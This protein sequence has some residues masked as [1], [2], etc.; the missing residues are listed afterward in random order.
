M[1]VVIVVVV[2]VGGVLIVRSRQV[3]RSVDALCTQMVAAQDLDQAFTTLDPATLDPQVKALEKARQ[4][5]PADIEPSVATLA[6]FVGEVAD[7]VD[8]A[9]GDRQQALTDALASRQGD[10]DGVTAAGTAVQQWAQANCGL[11][12]AGTTSSST[13]S[14][15]GAP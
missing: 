13:T 5:A 14:S 7:T 12:L 2:V 8:A 10:I 15:T 1:I 11:T 9:T 4:V 6:G 3:A